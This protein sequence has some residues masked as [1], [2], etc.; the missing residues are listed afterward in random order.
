MLK[1]PTFL[2]VVKSYVI[3]MFGTQLWGRASSFMDFIFSEPCFF[4]S[5]GLQLFTLSVHLQITFS[6]DHFIASPMKCQHIVKNA[7]NKGTNTSQTPKHLTATENIH[8]L[9]AGTN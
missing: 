9:D 8:I 3:L 2:D 1:E 6:I 7:R 4:M 5:T